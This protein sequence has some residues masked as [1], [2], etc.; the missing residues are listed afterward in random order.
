MKKTI[1]KRFIKEELQKIDEADDLRI[2]PFRSDGVT[3]GT[4][5]WIWAVVVAGRLYVRPY[6]REKSKW[7][8]A[9]VRQGKGR[10]HAAGMVKNVLFK[11]APGEVN[12]WIDDAYRKKYAGNTFLK[13]MIGSSIHPV[14]VRI[15]PL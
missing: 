13:T 6:H 5:T 12:K 2:S 4:P 11:S 7:Y 14:T 8:N 9:A 3:Y 15:E 1:S 10:I